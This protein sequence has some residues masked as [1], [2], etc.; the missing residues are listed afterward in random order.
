[1]QFV[2]PHFAKEILRQF[3]AHG[4]AAG[5]VS[6]TATAM[7]KS[8]MDAT[9]ELRDYLRAAGIHDFA[10]QAQGQENKKLLR[11]EYVRPGGFEPTKISLY[12]P[13]AKTGD[14]R[15]WFYGLNTYARADDV[16]AL[17]NASDRLFIVNASDPALLGTLGD[18]NTPLGSVVAAAGGALSPRA[19]ELFEKIRTI[20][21]MGFVP[22]VRSGD[23]GVGATLESLLGIASN[24]KK[25]PDYF[26]IEIKASRHRRSRGAAR[27][28]VNL[29]SQVPMWRDPSG[30]TA[31]EALSEYGY[32]VDGRQQLYCTVDALRPN[33]QGLMLQ[34]DADANRLNLLHITQAT[35]APVFHWDLATLR[36]RLQTKHPESFWVKADAQVADGTEY[37]HYHSIVHTNKPLLANLGLA[38]ADGTIT[39]DLTM[40]ANGAGVRDHGYLF[41]IWPEDLHVLFPEP[42]D[43]TL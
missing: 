37:F 22:S 15:I 3:G 41:K 43:Y 26:G 28:R 17:F 29:F 38:I 7:S 2:D 6:P 31:L 11:A 36:S 24:S 1:M 10:L 20:S 30:K 39:V 27:N 40:S 32:V 35:A 13:D 12:R 34:I 25:S 14:P 21:A 4:V 8:I 42:R 33:S 18:P 5:L 16:L 19:A 9:A 23:T